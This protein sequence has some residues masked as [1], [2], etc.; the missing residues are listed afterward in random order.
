VDAFCHHSARVV[1]FLSFSKTSSPKT[2][3]WVASIALDHSIAIY[4]VEDKNCLYRFFGH[5]YAIQRVYLKL[6]DDLFM[7]ETSDGSL[8]VW[9]LSTGVLDRRVFLSLCP[10]LLLDTEELSCTSIYTGIQKTSGSRSLDVTTVSDPRQDGVSLI[11]FH[12]NTKR[13]MDEIYNGMQV[14]T[15]PTPASTRNITRART[16]GVGESQ[17]SKDH[18]QQ[19]K[20]QQQPQRSQTIGVASGNLNGQPQQIKS[21][22]KFINTLTDKFRK[23]KGQAGLGIE[24]DTRRRT[25]AARGD[26]PDHD[27][28][29]SLFSALLSWHL[30]PAVDEMCVN[31]LGLTPPGSFVSLGIRGALGNLGLL[32]PKGEKEVGMQWTI[33]S[34]LN[35]IRLLNILSLAQ[36]VLAT[37]GENSLLRVVFRTNFFA[38]KKRI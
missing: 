31:Q 8:Y 5:E 1:G 28:V 34:T 21:P 3:P 24:T 29:Q 14:L 26:R 22:G 23:K 37:R 38:I 17:T 19:Q 30:D 4:T 25:T 13:L 7:V 11:V 35:G 2:R 36:A 20:E 10:E 15:P 32:A 18:L 6:A 12:V 9:Q 27:V 33:S 16:V